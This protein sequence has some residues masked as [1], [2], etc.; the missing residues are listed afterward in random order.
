[1]REQHR[2]RSF[3]DFPPVGQEAWKARV[4]KELGGTPYEEIL[5]EEEEGVRLDPWQHSGENLPRLLQ[6]PARAGNAWKSCRKIT[7]AGT[8]EEAAQEAN[9]ALR[10][11]AGALEFHLAHLGSSDEETIKRLLEGIDRVKTP[12]YFSGQVEHSRLLEALQSI[13][14]MES[15]PGGLLT[16]LPDGA[17]LPVA[18]KAGPFRTLAV[19]LFPLH[20]KGASPSQQIAFALAG[21]GDMLLR[22]AEAGVAPDKAIASMEVV[23]GVGSS[24]FTE[25]AKP[26]ALRALLVPVLEA[27]GASPGL[28]PRLFSRTSHSNLSPSDPY[29]NLLRLTTETVSAVL[30]GYET[31]QIEPY[32]IAPEADKAEAARLAGN[33]SLLLERE[34]HLDLV[35]D[36]ANGSASIEALTTALARRASEHFRTLEQA[37]GLKNALQSGLVESMLARS[38][39]RRSARRRFEGEDKRKTGAP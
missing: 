23:L 38:L 18:D 16:P 34:A 28:L 7:V 27:W 20:E 33:I 4:I 24:Y 3:D 25:I 9:R 8:P 35:A 30:G 13:E 19:D 2:E 17:P 6:P 39:E 37:G 5:W 14:G 10:E 36:P 11:G 1:M 15:N 29:T 31:I 32:D 21:V 12:L 26:R 22:A